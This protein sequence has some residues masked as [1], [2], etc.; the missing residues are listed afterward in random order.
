M[1]SAASDSSVRFSSVS[2]LSLIS[3]DTYSEIVKIHNPVEAEGLLSFFNKMGETP[4]GKTFLNNNEFKKIK[5]FV[6]RQGFDI[7]LRLRFLLLQIITM[8]FEDKDCKVH[9]FGGFCRELVREIFNRGS[10]YFGSDLD[11][12]FCNVKKGRLLME[13]SIIKLFQRLNLDFSLNKYTNSVLSL[14][15]NFVI[16]ENTLVVPVDFV[17]IYTHVAMCDF[18]VNN[19][20]MCCMEGYN[21]NSYV[22]MLESSYAKIKQPTIQNVRGESKKFSSLK[23]MLISMFET[24]YKPGHVSLFEFGNLLEQSIDAIR[25]GVATLLYS[26]EGHLGV[27]PYEETYQILHLSKLV[28]KWHLIR[29]PKIVDRGFT[30]GGKYP[31]CVEHTDEICP[32]CQDGEECKYVV[33]SCCKKPVHPTCLYEFL[34]SKDGSSLDSFEC[35]YCRQSSSVV[36]VDIYDSMDLRTSSDDVQLILDAFIDMKTDVTQ[37]ISVIQRLSERRRQIVRQHRDNRPSIEY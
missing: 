36:M 12:G 25:T 20:M 7:K 9:V 21:I 24:F 3:K 5:D 4:N 10:G 22:A 8:C 11:I 35:F 6:M 32:I 18:D 2:D 15:F 26:E 29:G 31:K 33:L 27:N 17:F 30:L 16:G 1:A 14:N 37:N 13:K 19:L 34:F 23:E 28:A